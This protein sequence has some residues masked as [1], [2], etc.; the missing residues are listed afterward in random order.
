MAGTQLDSFKIIW[1]K[2]WFI[3]Q[4]E[5]PTYQDRTTG[6]FVNFVFKTVEVL[7][8]VTIMQFV[9]SNNISLNRRKKFFKIELLVLPQ[10]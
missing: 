10:Q 6:E 1:H 8:A 5:F 9:P 3:F 2:R 7:F 4:V